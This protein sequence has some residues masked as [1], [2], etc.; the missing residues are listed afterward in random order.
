MAEKE[1]PKIDMDKELEKLPSMKKEENTKKGE[2]VITPVTAAPAKKREKGFGQK[3]KSLFFDD[4]RSVSEYLLTDIV[5]P[6]VKDLISDAVTGA[7]QMI[8]F[9]DTSA[10][11]SNRSQD[12]N[13]TYT[14]YSSYYSNNNHQPK[15]E[16]RPSPRLDSAD[17]VILSSRGEAEEVLSRMG[18]IVDRY[19]FVSVADLYEMVRIPSQYTDNKYGWND[20]RSARVRRVRDGYML[21]LPPARY[22]DELRF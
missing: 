18:D 6:A 20:M 21:D 5:V 14:S 17:S 15:R 13:S 1:M 12:R 10:R 19:D 22:E 3:L 4:S 9:G 8:L 7:V 11:H 2:K 16:S